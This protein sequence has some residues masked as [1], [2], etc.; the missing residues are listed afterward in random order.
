MPISRKALCIFYAVVGMIALIGTWGQILEYLPR[1]F[2]GTTVHFWQETLA[3]PASRFITVDI[4]FFALATSVWMLLEAR[5]LDMRLP[6]LYIVF[7][8]FGVSVTF[9]LF[10]FKR[11]RALG[12]RENTKQGGALMQR[13]VIG[14]AL[15]AAGVVA[16]AIFSFVYSSLSHAT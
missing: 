8:L 9:P 13:D 1:G 14:L 16:F 3:N 11:E 7:G 6:W 4:F 10:L 12:V 15:V 2:L 5:R